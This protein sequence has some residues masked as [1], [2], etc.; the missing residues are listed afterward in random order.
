MKFTKKKLLIMETEGNF[1]IC[2]TLLEG[3]CFFHVKNVGVRLDMDV[4][5]YALHH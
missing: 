4:Y 2:S 5:S 3:I 1:D